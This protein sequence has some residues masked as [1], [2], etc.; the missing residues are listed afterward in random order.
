[1][2]FLETILAGDFGNVWLVMFLPSFLLWDGVGLHG[3]SLD[4]TFGFF[5]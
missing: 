4:F 3:R 1:M 2:A 5:L